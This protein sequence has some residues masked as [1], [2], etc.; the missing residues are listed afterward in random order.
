[1]ARVQQKGREAVVR[2]TLDI[3]FFFVKGQRVDILGFI[4]HMIWSVT[5]LL[6]PVIVVLKQP[7]IVCEQ[8]GVPIKLYCLKKLQTIW[9]T[10][11]NL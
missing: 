1:M 9:S 11:C 2:I 4:G 6:I 8:V 7:Q 5:Q 10:G 3:F